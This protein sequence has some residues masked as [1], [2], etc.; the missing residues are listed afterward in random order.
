MIESEE[1]LKCLKT[2]Y[3]KYDFFV[4]HSFDNQNCKTR[5]YWIYGSHEALEHRVES[6]WD[7][8][9][10]YN[11][12]L[13]TIDLIAYDGYYKYNYHLISGENL[14]KEIM[15]KKKIKRINVI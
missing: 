11:Y 3:P 10:F 9:Y 8:S 2:K 1:L 13:D 14:H 5:L 12:I 15:R 6:T 4:Q 7:F